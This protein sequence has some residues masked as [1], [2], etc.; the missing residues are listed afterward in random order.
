MSLTGIRDLPQQHSFTDSFDKM[1]NRKAQT[2]KKDPGS[3]INYIPYT[4]E[5]CLD[6][7]TSAPS[8]QIVL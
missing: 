3:C 1:N 6:H 8:I 4:L 2:N 5:N 7:K